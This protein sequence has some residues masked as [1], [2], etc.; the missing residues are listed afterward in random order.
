MKGVQIY[1]TFDG[2]CH[3]A[4]QFYARCLGGELSVHKFSEMP[5][6]DPDMREKVKDRLMHARITRDGRDLLMASDSMPGHPFSMG[7]NFSISLAF[8]GRDELDRAFNAL[9]QGG[10]V[11]MPLQETFFADRF[12]ML[13]DRFGINW[14]VIVEKAMAP[15]KA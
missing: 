12:G 10:K 2:N 6:S 7:N 5:H 9:A 14:M 15:Q 11:T 3:E 1:L 4:M 8:D 13:T